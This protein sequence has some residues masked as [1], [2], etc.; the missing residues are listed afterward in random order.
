MR[1]WGC[2]LGVLLGLRLSVTL[3]QAQETRAI[4]S[5]TVADPQG[6]VMPSAKVEVKNLETN[7]VTTIETD[8]SGFYTS[9]PVNPG[10]Y[11]VTASAPGFKTT[12][13]SNVELRVGDRMVLDFQLRLGGAMETVNVTAEAPLLDTGSSSQSSTL[14]SHLVASLPTYGRDVF[15]LVH[16]TAGVQ[17]PARSTFG[18]RPFDGGDDNVSIAGGNAN[19][20]EVLLDGSPDTY[21]ETT[22]PANTISP[23]PDAVSEVKVQTNPYDAEYGRTG[24]GVITVSLKSGTNDY[25]GM[26]QWLWRNDILN[27]NTFE[28]NAGGGGKATFRMNEPSVE[29]QGPIRIPRLYDGRN[30][31]FFMYALDIY[32][33]SRPTNTTMVLPTDLERQGDFSQ[34]YVSGTSGSTIAIYDPLSTVQM[35]ST[36]T[37]TPFPGAKIPAA[38]INPIAAKVMGLVLPPNLSGI[39]RGQPNRLD[40]PN[41]DHEPFNSHVFR[42]DH[43]FSDKQRF[44]ANGTYNHRGQVNGLGYGLQA[45]EAAGTPYMSTSYQHWRNNHS[46]ALNLTSTLSPTLVATTR[47]S[48]Y[49][50]EFAIDLYGFESSPT[51]LGYP[52][53]LAAQAQSVSFPA[54]SIGGYTAI[55]P[56]RAGGNILNFSDTWAIGETLS[57]IKGNHNLRFGGDARLML[58]NQSSPMP[59]FSVG[60]NAAFTQAN[61]LVPSATS[62]DGLASFLLGYPS[63]LSSTY[64]NFP[65]EGQHYYG[66][67]FQDDWRVTRKL[68]LNLGIRWEYESPITDRFNHIVVG[69]DPT[70]TT[71]VGSPTGPQVKGGLLFA[72]GSHR[73][74]YKRDL[75]NFGPRAGYAYQVTSKLVIRGGWAIAYDPT[76]DVAPNTGFSITTSPSMSVANAGIVPLTQPGCSPPSCGMLSNPFPSGILQPMGSSLGLLTN[77]GSAIS[78]I[79]PGRVVPYSHTFSSG[80]QYQLPWRSVVQVSY[81]GRRSRDL[82]TSRNLNTVTY[83]QYLTYGSNLTA[84]ASQVTNPYAGLLPGTSLNGAKMTLQQSLLPYPQFTGITETGRSIGTARYDAVIVQWEKR[85]SSGLTVLFTGTFQNGT[86]YDTYLHPGM[87]AIGQFITRDSGAVPYIIN[88]NG[89]YAL[90]FFNNST[91]L[92]RTLFGGWQIAGFGQWLA[93]SML[94]VSG[95]TS[96]G[97]DPGIANATYTHRFNTCTF[98]DNTG[99]RQNCSSATEPVAWIIEKPFTL[100]MQPNPQWGSVRVKIP[101]STD[102]SLYKTFKTEGVN[103]TFRA[104]ANNAFNTPRFVNPNM[105]AT[106]SLFGVTTL[107][108]ANMPRSIQLGLRVSF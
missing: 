56:T 50:H 83:Q 100:I 28:A 54:I 68:T 74:P 13:R 69:F 22:A 96:T 51:V 103:V 76:A 98:N 58:N 16:Y 3:L 61:P 32:R 12:V 27:A 108:Q 82:P 92:T 99:S 106:S 5:G 79:Y 30:R 1:C 87:D 67:F 102:L 65:A 89:T 86:T 105:T 45:Y 34:T 42:F 84:P 94:D 80:I 7:L 48:W 95:A 24:S 21:R 35:G 93:G 52:A 8:Q 46:L 18:Q 38:L 6:A 37:R 26:A 55:G 88:L 60:T 25:H 59:T 23:P 41:F 78:Y 75:N 64:N 72:D 97:L 44:F 15:E 33:D 39:P 11:S 14:N 107:T 71:N 29:F 57:K 77:A 2:A 40:T 81:N 91:R 73:L 62:G 17:G 49:R 53:S 63:S 70:T 43:A 85:L 10:H 104:D 101:F 20:N 36:Y 90:P 47:A 66:F 4:V 9:P 19:A 31:T